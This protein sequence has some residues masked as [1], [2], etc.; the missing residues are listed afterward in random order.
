MDARDGVVAVLTQH[1]YLHAWRIGGP[2][3]PA[4]V[5]GPL[6]VQLPFTVRKGMRPASVHL[7][8]EGT[9]VGRSLIKQ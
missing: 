4:R 1:G 6:H 3:A 9:K 2:G 5:L 8:C 7:N